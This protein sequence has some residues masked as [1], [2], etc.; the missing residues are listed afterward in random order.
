MEDKV[1]KK[2]FKM[3]EFARGKIKELDVGRYKQYHEKLALRTFHD[4]LK[5][6]LRYKRS[7]LS[8]IV[9][10]DNRD[11]KWKG[12]Y[13]DRGSRENFRNKFDVF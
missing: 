6:V 13:G 11:H 9:W 5:E 1:E 3:N 2:L 7:K 12:I 10:S 4:R 8:N